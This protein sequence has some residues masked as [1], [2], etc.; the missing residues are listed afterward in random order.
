MAVRLAQSLQSP[1]T[2]VAGLTQAVQKWLAQDRPAAEAWMAQ[3][4][5]LTPEVRRR[6]LGLPS[7]DALGRS[8]R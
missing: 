7:V 5:A 6:I 1:D 3:T 8:Y 2:R 4:E